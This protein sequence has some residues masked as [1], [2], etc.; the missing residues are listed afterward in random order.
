MHDSGLYHWVKQF[1]GIAICAKGMPFFMQLLLQPV[2][3]L[4]EDSPTNIVL[5]VLVHEPRPLGIDLL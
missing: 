4:P 2:Q 3:V 1:A 5:V